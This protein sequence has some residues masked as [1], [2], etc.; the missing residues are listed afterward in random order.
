MKIG[1]KLNTLT[2]EKYFFYIDNHKKYTDFNTLGLYRSIVEH[3]RLSLEDKLKVRDY[4]HQTFRKAFDFLQLKDPS[5]YVALEYLGQELT[6]GDHR[7][8][9]DDLRK[10]QQKILADKKIK[11]R[12]FGDYS[13]HDCG[14]EACFLNGVMLKQ[15]SPLAMPGMH[16]ESDRNKIAAK[17]KSDRRKSER[18][19]KQQIVRKELEDME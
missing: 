12:N 8:I 5:T 9:W 15:G 17:A 3:E 19:R 6:Y 18:K 11:H 2:V 7:R 13:K 16:F 1:R 4:A 14:K 10:N